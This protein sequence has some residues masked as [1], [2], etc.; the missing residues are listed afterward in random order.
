MRHIA[1]I[2]SLGLLF[3]VTFCSF[4]ESRTAT[5]RVSPEALPTRTPNGRL[6]YDCYAV[7]IT[8]PGV[9]PTA[10]S[11]NLGSYSPDC[12]AWGIY[13]NLASAS[14]IT[15]GLRITL[16]AGVERKVTVYGIVTK[17]LGSACA[18]KS[19]TALFDNNAIPEIY[20]LATSANV[21]LVQDAKL[22][23]T[24]TTPLGSET[25]LLDACF[26][27]NPPTDIPPSAVTGVKIVSVHDSSPG[28]AVST[29]DLT[30]GALST[31]L[32]QSYQFD[33]GTLLHASPDSKRVTAWNVGTGG[34]YQFIFSQDALTYKP[35]TILS[36]DFMART[37]AFYST[38][39]EF[40]YFSSVSEALLTRASPNEYELNDPS[41]G[42][43]PSAAVQFARGGFLYY[44][45]TLNF[46]VLYSPLPPTWSALSF[47]TAGVT[48]PDSLVSSVYLV[49]SDGVFFIFGADGKTY[50]QFAKFQ[51]D[52]KLALV[53]T[54]RELGSLDKNSYGIAYASNQRILV[55][56]EGS[57]NATLRSFPVTAAGQ[58]DPE[59]GQSTA[60]PYFRQMYMD[61]S[62][63]FLIVI[64][65]VSSVTSNIATYVVGTSGTLD[66]QDSLLGKLPNKLLT[67]V[68]LATR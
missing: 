18:G 14:E 40:A 30:T 63:R 26:P 56:S 9:S 13:S 20:P 29:L 48:V 8:G 55:V 64:S 61:P 39:S 16:P 51:G 2:C 10:G 3:V 15:K 50:V 52:G 7:S 37:N 59:T 19:A 1:W 12:L 68:P 60:I 54:A 22:E 35:D 11:E 67:T 41:R 27:T 17:A 5:V 49:T 6:S 34:H 25:N 45:S 23:L 24:R 38:N 62:A 46:A 53:G 42:T 21:K 44:I 43:L 36:S 4:T 66:F 31:P 65:V 33:Q 58:I 47:T 32:L 28:F 57:T